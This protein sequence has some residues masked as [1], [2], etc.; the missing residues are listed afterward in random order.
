MVDAGA[1][2]RISRQLQVVSLMRNLLNESF[3]SSAGPRWVYAPGR[4]G[5]VTVVLEF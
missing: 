5:S 4:R 3:Y 1:S 2:W